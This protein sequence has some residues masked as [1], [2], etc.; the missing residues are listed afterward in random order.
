MLIYFPWNVFEK[1][2]KVEDLS[3]GKGCKT[4]C[5][6]ETPKMW[7]IL[8][9]KLKLLDCHGRKFEYVGI[10]FLQSGTCGGFMEVK[11]K[12]KLKHYLKNI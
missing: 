9:K 12:R 3:K 8:P 5:M 2:K 7:G 10:S 6:P 4:F 1:G 11:F